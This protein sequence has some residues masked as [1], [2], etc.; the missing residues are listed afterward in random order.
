MI[1]KTIKSRTEVRDKITNALRL[2]TEP[3]I[4]TLSPLGRNVIY[5]DRG[6]VNQTNDG[7]T[8]AKQIQSDDPIEQLIIEAVKQ[9]A[10][11]TNRDAGDGTTTTILLTSVLANGAMKLVDDGINP[12]VLSKELVKFGDQLISSIKPILVKTDADLKNIARI[13]ANNDEEIATHVVDIVK[14]AGQDGMVFLEAGNK[15]ETVIEKD[16]GFI[17]DGGLFSPEYAQN[18]GLVSTFED[19]H[20]LVCDKAIYYEEEAET[21]LRTAIESGV[22]KLVIVAKDFIGKSVN[23]FSANH[24]RNKAIKLI[25]VKDNQAKNTASLTDLAVYL[26]ANLISDK[27]GKLVDNLKAEDFC[28]AKK[29]YANPQRTVI[30]TTLEKEDVKYEELDKRIYA[31]KQEKEKDE[32]N[33]AITRRLAALTNGIVTVRVGGSTLIEV[34]ERVFRY[35]DAINATRSA[36]KHG[37]VVGGGLA[38]LGAFN[39]SNHPTELAPLFRRFCEASVRQIAKNCGKHEETILST[40]IPAVCLG[41]NAKTDTTEDLLQAGIIDPYKV[42]ELAIRNAISVANVIIT[43]EWYIAVLKDDK[44]NK[45]E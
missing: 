14:T 5:E 24:A 32:S 38:L 22:Q 9:A 25:L 44:T 30:T 41:Y 29:V 45:D 1:H 40:C 20:V 26:G 10:L 31:L 8:I 23:V 7:V 12:M 39:P 17:V 19:C 21:I 43:T 28:L 3:V 6:G 34:Q 37:Y 15:G 35:E 11:S 33:D 27:T 36:M 16:S 2:I 18:Q 13:S 4:Q 42:Q